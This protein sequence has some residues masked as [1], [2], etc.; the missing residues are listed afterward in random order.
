MSLSASSACNALPPAKLII[1][2]NCVGERLALLLT[3]LF[4]RQDYYCPGLNVKWQVVSTPPIYNLKKDAWEGLFQEALKCDLVFS[5]PLFN[6]GPCNTDNLKKHLGSKLHLFSAPNF[7]A[8]FPDAIGHSTFNLPEKFSPPLE[9]HS[10]IFIL[11]FAAGLSP[12][13]VAH[14]YPKHALFQK[15]HVMDAISKTLQRYELRETDVEIGTL[16]ETLKNYADE[17][18]F[19]T[20]NHPG[21]RIIRKLLT[22]M[23]SVLGMKDND[24]INALNHI[25]WAD[26][27]T[28]IH[29][30]SE[31]GFGFNSW[32]IIT[33]NHDL[34]NF[35]TRD[36][37]RI[38]GQQLSL[39]EAA[40]EWYK[41]YQAH[42]AI[43]AKLQGCIH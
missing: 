35:Q 11:G 23:L 21:D 17:P 29:A 24:V 16:E 10:H 26:K 3:G 7:E 2:G 1:L 28:D 12:Q 25:P 6:F 38:S 8:Y 42:P 39:A 4:E 18:L 33:D 32:P 22:G 37:F 31:W 27:S 43:F 15:K 13:E 34:F 14:I 9:W 20:F 40:N 36:W 5:Q 41:Y 19:F 30:W